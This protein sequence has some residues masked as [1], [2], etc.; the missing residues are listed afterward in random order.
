MGAI[1]LA[2]LVGQAELIVQARVESVRTTQPES[3]PSPGQKQEVEFVASSVA[4][5][6]VDKVLKGPADIRRISV[7]FASIEDS[8]RYIAGETV[9]VFLTKAAKEDLYTT[10]GMMQGRYLIKDGM[11]EREQ[12]PVAE[13]LRRIRAMLDAPTQPGR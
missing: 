2:E 5:L 11:V 6:S 3:G 12:I 9:V 4:E 1:P 7:E 10:V 13:F 8:P